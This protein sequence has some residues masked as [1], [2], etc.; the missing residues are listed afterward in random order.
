MTRWTA[1]LLICAGCAAGVPDLE[2]TW[3]RTVSAPVGFDVNGEPDTFCGE[4]EHSFAFD[5]AGAYTEVQAT[6]P[7]PE[8]EDCPANAAPVVITR[9][10][11]WTKVQRTEDGEYVLAFSVLHVDYD[12][13]KDADDVSEDYAVH[14]WTTIGW[15]VQ[16]EA[17]Y[18]WLYDVGLFQRM[19]EP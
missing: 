15:S 7:D 8:E 6:T 12:Y 10:G 18:L 2:G 19:G 14:W 13:E 16:P 4:L 3:S 17:E 5:A 11:T 1:T 9:T